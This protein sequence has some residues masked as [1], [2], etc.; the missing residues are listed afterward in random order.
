MQSTISDERPAIKRY[1]ESRLNTSQA[2]Y[3]CLE[4]KQQFAF[5]FPRNASFGDTL[6]RIDGVLEVHLLRHEIWKSSWSR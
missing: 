5:D 3:V 1:F 4:C 6:A 2:I